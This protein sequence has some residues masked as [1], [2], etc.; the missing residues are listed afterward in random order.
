MANFC[1]SRSDNGTRIIWFNKG[2][3]EVGLPIKHG[4]LNTCLF[5]LASE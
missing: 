3:S 4:K 5:V 1:Y 2:D